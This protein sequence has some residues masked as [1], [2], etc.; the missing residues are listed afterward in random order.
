MDLVQRQF[1]QHE[2]C[3]APDNC[4]KY[5]QNHNILLCDIKTN[6][7]NLLGKNGNNYSHL[8]PSQFTFYMHWRPMVH[9][10]GT[11][12]EEDPFSHHEGMCTDGYPDGQMDGLT[13]G[14]MD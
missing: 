3:M 5:E 9:D 8:V 14:W 12:Y 6:I 10:H 2:Q 7:K 4:T 13:D 11:Q 1:Y